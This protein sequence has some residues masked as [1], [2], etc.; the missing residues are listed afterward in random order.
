MSYV[1]QGKLHFLT[2]HVDSKEWDKPIQFLLTTTIH[3]GNVIITFHFKNLCLIPRV[4][5]WGFFLLFLKYVCN[6]ALIFNIQ[7]VNISNLNYKPI[8]LLY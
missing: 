6:S 5:V 2:R 3:V 7:I 8:S 1:S 4:C